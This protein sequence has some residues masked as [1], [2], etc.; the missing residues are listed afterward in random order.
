MDLPPQ[1]ESNILDCIAD[2]ILIC[3]VDDFKSLELTIMILEQELRELLKW[4]WAKLN[5]TFHGHLF[6]L[7]SLSVWRL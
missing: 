1:I 3:N 6:I 4:V 7:C 5:N 2:Q